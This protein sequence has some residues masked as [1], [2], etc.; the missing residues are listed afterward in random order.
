M[1][2]LS[3]DEWKQ[4]L[5]PEQYKILRGKGTEMPGSGKL[6]HNDASGDYVCGACGQVVFQSGTK[7][8][9]GT[10]WPSFYEPAN[11]AAIKLVEDNKFLMRRTEVEC[12]N[13][14]GHLGHVFNDAP[15]QPTGQRFCINS[16]ALDFKKQ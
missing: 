16:A 11:A 8:D 5:T 4:K 1:Q 13:C 6:L 10:G 14:G 12:A 2:Q 9:S 15:N 7:F 3:D